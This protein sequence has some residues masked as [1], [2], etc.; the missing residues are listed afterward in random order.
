MFCLGLIDLGKTAAVQGWHGLPKTFEQADDLF[1]LAQEAGRP[2]CGVSTVPI[3]LDHPRQQP[4]GLNPVPP[5][6]GAQPHHLQMAN[7][8][9]VLAL[10]G[11]VLA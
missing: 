2:W 10:S 5:F 7:N 6:P 3:Q 11:E 1:A 8:A 4:Q 9:Q